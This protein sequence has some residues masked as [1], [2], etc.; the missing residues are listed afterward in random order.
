MEHLTRGFYTNLE[1]MDTSNVVIRDNYGP[2]LPRLAALKARYDPMNL[3]RLNA[4]V[5]P[6]A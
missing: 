2:N 5:L 1:D 6:S 4:N 3:F